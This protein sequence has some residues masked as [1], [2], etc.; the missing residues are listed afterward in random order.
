[1]SKGVFS[2]VTRLNQ[3]GTRLDCVLEMGVS[4]G[5][6]RINDR[7][8]HLALREFQ[9]FFHSEER[10]GR[11]WL[12]DPLID[13]DLAAFLGLLCGGTT[14]LLRVR[15]VASLSFARC[16]RIRICGRKRNCATQCQCSKRA[17]RAI[18]QSI[19]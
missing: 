17:Q 6:T 14:L 8:A 5:N 11:R 13:T 4:C 19:H 1:M 7:D 12:S 18:C 10:V 2:S 9:G 16:G 15:L 3:V